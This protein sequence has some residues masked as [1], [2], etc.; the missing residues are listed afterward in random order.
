MTLSIPDKLFFKIG[1]VSEITK[2][3]PY[4]L[5]YWESEFPVLKPDKNKAGQRLYTKDNIELVIKIKSLLYDDK[6]TIEGARKFL[7]ENK[8][9][10]SQKGTSDKESKKELSNCLTEVKID[11]EELLKKL[12][13]FDIS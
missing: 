5:R 1:E 8:K 12:D 9:K 11:L 4:I 7:I 2:L 13:K 3:E 10:K 6:Y